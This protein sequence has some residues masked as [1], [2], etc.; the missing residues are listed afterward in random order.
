MKTSQQFKGKKLT[1]TT[2]KNNIL[3]MWS[4]A[5]VIDKFDWYKNANEFCKNIDSKLTMQQKVGVLAALSP[6]RRW[7][8]NKVLALQMIKEGNAK[9][10]PLFINKAKDIIKNGSTDEKIID[11]LGGQKIISFYLNILY[12]TQSNI[13]TIDRHALSIALGYKVNEDIYRGMTKGQYQFFVDCYIL[14]AA[15]VG[16]H[17]LLMQSATWEAFRRL[18]NIK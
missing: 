7:G 16:V 5:T 8:T 11:I 12:P 1:R 6:Q 17:T 10:M 2:V 9:H 4:Q 15:K 14:A 3:K 13:V 18:N